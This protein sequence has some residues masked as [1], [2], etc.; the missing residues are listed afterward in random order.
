[1]K[2]PLTFKMSCRVD[3]KIKADNEEVTLAKFRPKLSKIYSDE[4]LLQRLLDMWD[5]KIATSH[6]LAFLYISDLLSFN[7]WCQVL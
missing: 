6:M 4:L 3:L 7:H 5:D 1:M 2:K